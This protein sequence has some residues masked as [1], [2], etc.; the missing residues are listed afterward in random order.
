MGT[1]HA[2]G[3]HRPE[4]RRRARHEPGRGRLRPPRRRP[5]P[6]R[7]RR[8]WA[9]RSPTSTS[10]T[11]ASTR[12]KDVS[13]SIEPNAVTAFI[14]S[15][16]CGKST[17]LR[18]LNRMH[19]VIHGARAEGRRPARR[20]GHLRARTSTRCWSARKVGMVFQA[21]NPF[22]TM[23][24]YDNVAAGLKLN[25]ARI[26]Q[27][28]A[29]RGRRAL[30]ARRAPVGGG[31]GPSRPPRHGPLGRPAAAPVHR[32]R[33]RGRARGPADGRARVGARPD[34]DPGH[35]GPGRRS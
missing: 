19:E 1:R 23:S 12:C 13:M 15:S 33:D 32:A 22:P 25:K 2:P 28:R 4:G 8:R 29:R 27:G 21:P 24:I 3:P 6:R 35:R 18:S 5:P 16:G 30:A 10:S 31:Q 17:L 34:R 11:A 20:P 7:R 26:E 9:S 14:G